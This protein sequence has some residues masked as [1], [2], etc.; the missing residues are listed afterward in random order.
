MPSLTQTLDLNGRKVNIPVGLFINGE[1]RESKQKNWLDVEDPS[2]SKKL[3]SIV[4]G[5]EDDV[6]EAVAIARERFEDESWSQSNPVYR[7][8]LLNKLADLMEVHKEDIVAIE[9]ADTGKTPH[10][11]ASL[12]FPGSVGTLRYYAGWVSRA[13]G[14]GLHHFWTKKAADP[15]SH[16]RTKSSGCSPR[17]LTKSSP[18]RDGNP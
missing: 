10:H 3:T 9:C 12:D 1:F 7:A 11:C 8:G 13:A 14:H 16:R 6:D 17:T 15:V 5:R 4:E 18:I 2:T